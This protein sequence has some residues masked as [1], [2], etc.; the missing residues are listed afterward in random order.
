MKKLKRTSVGNVERENERDQTYE[1]KNP[2]IDLSRTHDNYHIIAPPLSYMEFINKRIASLNLKRKVR[3]DA[4]Y[5]NTFVLSSGHEFFE[6]MPLDRQ[7]NKNGCC[8]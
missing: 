2:K 7:G 8:L 3:S 6:N 1:A 4:I 5:M